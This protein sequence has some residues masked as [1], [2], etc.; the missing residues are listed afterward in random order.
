MKCSYKQCDFA[1]VNP[2]RLR[3]HLYNHD[4][5]LFD[6]KIDDDSVDLDAKQTS[7][8]NSSMEVKS[9]KLKPRIE[10]KL[11]CFQISSDC[12]I[13]VESTDSSVANHSLDT[14]GV[15]IIHEDTVF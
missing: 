1:S 10:I 12:F 14:G 15:T 6:K 3:K 9:A 5:G 2:E 8:L 13:P 4:L 7:V 11:F